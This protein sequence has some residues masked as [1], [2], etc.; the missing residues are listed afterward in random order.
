MIDMTTASFS[1]LFLNFVLSMGVGLT[2]GIER[3]VNV[4]E[5]WK[6]VG[7]RD[8]IMI[9]ALAFVSSLF[10]TE[11]PYPWI[12][13]FIAIILFTLS[14]FIIRNIRVQ[15]RTVGMTTLLAL[16]FTFLVASL[17]NFGAPFWAIVTIIFVVLLVLGMKMRIYQFVR[18]IERAEIIDFALLMGIAISITPLIP[19]A[20]RLPIPLIDFNGYDTTLSYKYVQFSALWKVVVTVSLMSFIAH[21]VTKYVHGKNALLAATFLGGLVSSLATT[22]MLLRNADSARK[23]GD[24]PVVLTQR[25]LFLGFMSSSTGSAIKDLFILHMTIG[26]ELFNKFAFPMISI[27]VYFAALTVYAFTSAQSDNQSIR[28][29]H[30]P[31]PLTFIFKFSGTLAALIIGMTM[32]TYYAGDGALI[33]ASFISGAISS[34]AAITSIAA[35]MLQD[36]PI[37]HWTAGL[38]I[39]GAFLGS[40]YA[41]YIAIARH[42]G[43]RQSAV[44]LLPLAGLAI[45]GIVTLWIS[46]GSQL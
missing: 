36:T 40:N 12:G 45:I 30:R 11:T 38:A 15:E 4:K 32:L 31:L 26:E 28:I 17:P 8:F 16:P 27:L 46:L 39:V 24:A 9:A 29:T 14:I 34:G 33:P 7:M 18:T 1:T 13:T 3:T 35:A 10:Y 21:F 2:L 22:L 41:K 6:M 44:F 5:D 23:D 19:A 43:F 42:S 20:A 25:Q 37:T